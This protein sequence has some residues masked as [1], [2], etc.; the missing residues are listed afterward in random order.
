MRYLQ[1]TLILRLVA[2]SLALTGLLS[3]VLGSGVTA[4]AS[5]APQEVAS[6][7]SALGTSG[8]RVHGGDRYATSA[9][10]SRH[11]FPQGADVVYLARGDEFADAL[12]GGMLT[13][14]PILLVRA[15]G[16][17]PRSVRAEIARLNPSQVVALGGPNAVCDASLAEAAAGRPASRLAGVNRYDTAVEISLRAWPEPND[18]DAL[19][20]TSGHAYADAV[21]GGGLNDG[22]V[23]LVRPDGS[24]PTSVLAELGRISGPPVVGL[25]GTTVISDATLAD[26]DWGTSQL[27]DRL[28]GSNR[29][30]TAV[31]IAGRAYPEGPST[32]YLARGDTL[33]DAVAAG[34]L[35]DGPV[36][37]VGPT[38][39]ALRTSVKTYLSL[40]APQQVLALGGQGAVCDATVD[41]AVAAAT[42]SPALPGMQ[43]SGGP[44]LTCGVTTDGET[45]CWGYN[46]GGGLGDGTLLDRPSPGPVLGLGP[47]TTST[48][49]AG[50]PSCALLS[51]G[52]VQCWGGNTE[53]S[54]P[55]AGAYTAVPVDIPRLGAGTTAHISL[56]QKHGCAISITGATRC[57]GSNSSSQLGVGLPKGSLY[58]LPTLV[59]GF[60]PGTT[61]QIDAFYLGTCAVRLDSSAWCWGTN[62]GG[63]IGDGTRTERN[64]PTAVVGLGPGT[65]AHIATGTSHTCAVTT[66]GAAKCWGSSATGALGNGRLGPDVLTPD[67]VVGLGEGTT[68]MIDAGSAYACAVTTDGTAKCW[69]TNVYGKLGIGEG[70]DFQLAPHPVI[71]LTNN[72]NLIQTSTNTTCAITTSDELRCWGDNHLGQV[73]DGTTTDR[74]TP[75]P[76]PL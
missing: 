24:Y 17:V 2:S 57:W 30:D 61:R 42:S 13:D 22:P 23:L 10:I 48:I 51:N 32:V 52:S 64:L 74:R 33:V 4:T 75:V 71:G 59:P 63:R 46:A 14:G 9:A 1:R 60:G 47:G 39:G 34:G 66:E 72:T 68:T 54:I 69:G 76:I 11:A 67:D 27:P 18:A 21:A 38:C 29:Y 15:C 8:G 19:Y 5:S 3:G 65:T 31:T 58:A 20:A 16:G 7:A 45:K 43:I 40:V 73:G 25:G 56:G 70:I 50:G 55:G 41:A 35:A 12:A 36:L 37:L 44:S 62:V 28:H 26:M 49:E 53:G 6:V